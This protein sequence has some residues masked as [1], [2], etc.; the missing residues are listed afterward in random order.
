MNLLILAE[1]ASDFNGSELE[2]LDTLASH[3]VAHPVTVVL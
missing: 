3:F 1:A 2:L